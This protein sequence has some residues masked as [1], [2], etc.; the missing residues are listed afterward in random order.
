MFSPAWLSALVYGALAL[1]AI[2]LGILFVLLWR[3]SR[4]D[5]LW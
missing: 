1:A 3:D 5:E 4:S 2:G